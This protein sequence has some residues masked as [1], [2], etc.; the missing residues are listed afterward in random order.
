MWEPIDINNWKDIP[1]ISGRSATE[2]D[3]SEGRAAFYAPAGS[4]PYETHLPLFAL[5]LDEESNT[6]VP[7][8]VIQI[9][10]TP[11]GTAVGVRYVS[12]GNGVAMANEFEFYSEIPSEISL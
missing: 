3:V 4:E 1:C 5:Q 2:A 9:E 6:K 10:N 12:G 7:C 8:I 11:E